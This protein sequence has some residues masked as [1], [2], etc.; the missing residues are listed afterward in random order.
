MTYFEQS[1]N[2]RKS[3]DTLPVC[4]ARC[5]NSLC[6]RFNPVQGIK[7]PLRILHP[8]HFDII[9]TKS[10]MIATNPIEGVCSILKDIKH[11]KS[12]IPQLS[13]CWAWLMQCITTSYKLVCLG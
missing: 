12:Q 8:S 5:I 2:A 7:N 10:D 9:D 11:T 13:S 4:V 3:Y 1:S 6:C